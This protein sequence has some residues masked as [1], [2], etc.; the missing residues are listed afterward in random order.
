VHQR[1]QSCKPKALSYPAEETWVPTK[2]FQAFPLIC[3]LYYGNPKVRG[4]FLSIIVIYVQFLRILN[5]HTVQ[6]SLFLVVQVWL[7]IILYKKMAYIRVGADCEMEWDDIVLWKM[8]QC[9]RTFCT[10][11]VLFL[12]QLQSICKVTT[13]K[14]TYLLLTSGT[15]MLATL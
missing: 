3:Q 11:T 5:V 13:G 10:V 9:E 1:S 8:S 4:H 15:R 14:R 12:S 7:M 6:M 2:I